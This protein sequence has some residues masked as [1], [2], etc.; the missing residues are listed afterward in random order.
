[1]RLFDDLAQ[2]VDRYAEEYVD[3]EQ[4]QNEYGHDVDEIVDVEAGAETHAVVVVVAESHGEETNERERESVVELIGQNE[5]GV[6][7]MNVEEIGGVTRREAEREEKRSPGEYDERQE[8]ETT[9]EDD[10]EHGDVGARA[11]EPIRDALHAKYPNHVDTNNRYCKK[12]VL[13][14]CLFK[15]KET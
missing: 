8:V 3:S 5:V 10:L 1:M 7:G 6:V 4:G 2:L 11:K 12:I 15:F 9:Y 14:F 13:F